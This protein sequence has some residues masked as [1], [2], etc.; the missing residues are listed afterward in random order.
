MNDG[1]THTGTNPISDAAAD[2]RTPPSASSRP[3]GVDDELIIA[4]GQ[5]TPLQTTWD[6]IG[7]AHV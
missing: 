1:T 6:E 7:R 3:S 5:S 4:F 2:T